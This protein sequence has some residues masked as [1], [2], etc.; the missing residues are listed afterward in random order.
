ML[1][2]LKEL[3]EKIYLGR[4]KNIVFIS[5]YNKQIYL[6]NNKKAQKINYE[7]I[8]NPVNDIFFRNEPSENKVPSRDVYF[9]GEIKKRKGLHLL[10]QAVHGLKQKNLQIR[11]HVIGGGIKRK[12]TDMRLKI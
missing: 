9:V 11:V 10:L 2:R 5:D 7:L 8:V 12:N 4:I 6:R 1:F 3:T